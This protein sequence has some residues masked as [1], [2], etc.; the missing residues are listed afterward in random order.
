M[1]QF[2]VHC[3]LPCTMATH[4]PV[5]TSIMLH[6][7]LA[8]HWLSLYTIVS[9]CLSPSSPLTPSDPPGRGHPSP[10]LPTPRSKVPTGQAVTGCSHLLATCSHLWEHNPRSP[11]CCPG[12]LTPDFWWETK[13]K[14][15]YCNI[16]NF[17][18]VHHT[19]MWQIVIRLPKMSLPGSVEP[20][21]LLL[22][23]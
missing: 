12:D 19:K 2:I 4:Y 20:I 10:A 3:P 17:A 7:N 5:L 23:N 22:P 9:N 18:V 13:K 14:V 1:P 6:S 21:N 16:S 8:S 15:P 11:V